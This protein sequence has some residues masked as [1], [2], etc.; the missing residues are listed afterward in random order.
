MQCP[1]SYVLDKN[2]ISSII[3]TLGIGLLISVFESNEQ[4]SP[5]RVFCFS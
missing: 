5:K 3:K 4:L 1:K 2:S